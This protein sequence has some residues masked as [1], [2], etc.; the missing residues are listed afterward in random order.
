VSKHEIVLA[1]LAAGGEGA[2]FPPAQVQKLLFLI[3]REIPDAVGGP[4]FH[5]VPYNYGPFDS[6]VYTHLQTEEQNG[7]INVDRTGRYQRYSLTG[8]GMAIG[9]M[10]LAK[11]PEDVQRFLAD[12]ATWVNKLTFSQLV[13]AI[14]KHYPDMKVNT[15][16]RE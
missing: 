9:K 11:L 16:F 7:Y 2:S 8:V 15:V 14:Y 10:V 3:D 4:H 12:T 5:F 13:S 1:A 6:D